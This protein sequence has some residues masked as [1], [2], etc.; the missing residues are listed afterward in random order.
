MELVKYRVSK[1]VKLEELLIISPEVVVPVGEIMALR[2][3][4]K[5]VEYKMDDSI[6]SF[7]DQ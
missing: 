7:E 2:P 1:G 3:H 6:P 4:A 5:V